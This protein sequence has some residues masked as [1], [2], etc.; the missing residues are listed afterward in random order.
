MRHV[1]G[2][3]NTILEEPLPTGA[4]I[5]M[6]GAT[7]VAHSLAHE[8]V[9]AFGT[10]VNDRKRKSNLRPAGFKFSARSKWLVPSAS[11]YF[12]ETDEDHQALLGF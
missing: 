8:K 1:V 9:N 7:P 10:Q 2:L 11:R 3:R 4:A 5:L 6:T 12:T